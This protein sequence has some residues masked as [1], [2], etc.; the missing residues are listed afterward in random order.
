MKFTV[1]YS[2]KVKAGKAYEMMEIFASLESDTSIETMEKAF[3]R[4]KRFVDHNIDFERDR[5]LK[6][7]VERPEV[8]E[9]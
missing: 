1:S 6:E 4:V 3:A 2:R 5:L 9:K 8:E 7:S